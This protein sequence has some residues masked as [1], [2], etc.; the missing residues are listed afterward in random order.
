MHY[1]VQGLVLRETDYKDNDKLLTILTEDRGRLTARARGVKSRRSKLKSGCQLLTFS[2]FSIYEN[3]GFCTVEEAV[4]L[5]MFIELRTDIE[6][7]ALS[8]YFAQ[9]GEKL[10]LEDFPTPRLLSLTLNCIYALCRLRKPQLQVK[11]AFE[12][13]AACLAGYEPD[14]SGCNVCGQPFP[15]Y[16]CVQQGMLHCRSCPGVEN[17][18][19]RMPVCEASLA[20]MRH[21]VHGN[22]KQMFSFQTTPEVLRQLSGITETYLKMQLEQSFSALDFY[23]SL[24]IQPNEH[25]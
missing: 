25:T 8:S 19:L 6:L 18:G 4:P 21:I 22:K 5:D 17:H 10:A 13:S 16:F 1:K 14:L 20:A 7:L 2:E 24:L 3:R 12:L 9:V 11:A 15:E 23:K